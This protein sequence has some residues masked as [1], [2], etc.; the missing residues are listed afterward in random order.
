M[1][2][3]PK[4]PTF[5]RMDDAMIDWWYNKTGEHVTKDKVAE[6]RHAMQGHPEAGHAWE[7]FITAALHDISFHNTTHEKNI[8]QMTHDGF[9]ILVA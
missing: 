3:A 6:L 9:V 2:L 4:K 7:I 1:H 5:V 8:H